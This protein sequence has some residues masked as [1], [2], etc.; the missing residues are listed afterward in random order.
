[1]NLQ[2]IR[3]ILLWGFI[4]FLSLT[5][6]IAVF[7]ILSHQFGD[8]Q[9]KVIFTTLTI[10]GTSICAMCCA[11]FIEKKGMN[12]FCWIGISSAVAAAALTIFGIWMEIEKDDYWK[13]AGTLIVA[14]VA[15][16]QTF[17]LL[18]PDL[19]AAHRWTRSVF[20]LFITILALQ[21]IYAVWAEVDKDEYYR[22]IAVVSILVVL[23]TLVIPICSKLSGQEKEKPERLVLWPG[24]DGIY[25]DQSGRKFQ[26]TEIQNKDYSGA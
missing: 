1:M 16:A 9:L 26:V 12:V 8:T 23:M 25:T 15:F 10:S 13:T 20:I 19:A 7:S 11:A 17:L 4:G 21:I 3:R 18:I 6:L 2:K 5:A 24:A 22:G 14:A